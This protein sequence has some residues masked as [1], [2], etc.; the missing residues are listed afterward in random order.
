M[1][2]YFAPGRSLRAF[3]CWRLP[4]QALYTPVLDITVDSKSLIGTVMGFNEAQL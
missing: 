3:L 4:V 1:L 2:R